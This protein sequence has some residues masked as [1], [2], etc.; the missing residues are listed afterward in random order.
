MI[1][2]SDNSVSDNLVSIQLYMITDRER[3][4]SSISFLGEKIFQNITGV[5]YKIKSKIF[6]IKEG[7]SKPTRR[8]LENET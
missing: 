8:K 4:R 3:E 6:F 2:R 7:S 1:R 5:G